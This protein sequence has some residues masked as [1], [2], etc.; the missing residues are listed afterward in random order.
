MTNYLSHSVTTQSL[1][2]PIAIKIMT[3]TKVTT[4]LAL[5]LVNLTSL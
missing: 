3:K 4:K 2:Y 1:H 5:F